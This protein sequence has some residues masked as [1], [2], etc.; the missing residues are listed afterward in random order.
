[1]AK[2]IRPKELKQPDQ[3]VGFWTHAWMAVG[4]FARRNRKALV[5]GMSALA[6][7]IV[8]SVVMAQVSDRRAVKASAALARIERIAS[9]DLAPAGAPPKPD[10]KPETKPDDLPRFA[11]EKERLEAALKELDGYFTSKLIPLHS[12]AMLVRAGILLD[13][14][15]ADE[16]AAAYDKLLGGRLDARLKFLARE[17]LGYALER[18]GKLP[19]AQAAFAKLSEESPAGG[20]Y[21][22][23]AQ[24]HQARLAELRGNR[25]DAIRI[26]KEVLE[27]NP[28]TSLK[29]EVANRLA[30][31]E[32]K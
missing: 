25:A 6:T 2:K 24:Y 1:V 20:F 8:G 26:Y 28:N 21:Q 15:R 5:I 11:T 9:T 32:L 27:K 7:V 22:D 13:L 30:T 10:A 23:R 17:G 12:E 18:Q 4:D 14:G 19:E 31:L 16:A 3:F 29:D